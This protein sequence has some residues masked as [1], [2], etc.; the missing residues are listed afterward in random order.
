M[1]LFEVRKTLTLTLLLEADS[2]EA[3]RRQAQATP[4]LEWFEWEEAERE[5]TLS[6]E[7]VEV[8]F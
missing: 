2:P 7:E 1:A 5:P 8:P 6:V 3:A 4:D